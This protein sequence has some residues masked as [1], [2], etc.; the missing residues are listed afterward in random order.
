[1]TKNI[2]LLFV[3]GCLVNTSAVLAFPT[4]GKTKAKTALDASI[5]QDL[6]ISTVDDFLKLTPRKIKKATGKKL[7]IKEIIQ[8]KTAQQ[9]LNSTV[10][11]DDSEMPKW[12]YILLGIFGLAWIVMGIKDNWEGKNWWM[13]IIWVV[14][15]AILV[16]IIGIFCPFLWL[17]VMVP[18]LI[19]ALIKM[20]EYY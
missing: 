11:V 7:T 9:T 14:G 8:L 12:L 19:H 6:Q 15:G 3:I 5:F 16:T 2:I 13:N 18:G 17:L 4:T 20:K 1:M 10:A